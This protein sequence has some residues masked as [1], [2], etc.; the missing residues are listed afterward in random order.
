[1]INLLRCFTN[2]YF[3]YN[4]TTECKYSV[5]LTVT[6]TIPTF[7]LSFVWSWA[8]PFISN[9][10]CRIHYQKYNLCSYLMIGVGFCVCIESVIDLHN[11]K[12]PKWVNTSFILS[13]KYYFTLCFVCFSFCVLLLDPSI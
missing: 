8:F 9:I 12:T 13:I 10:I 5:L 1:M 11:I 7:C 4:T 2:I 6:H 3:V